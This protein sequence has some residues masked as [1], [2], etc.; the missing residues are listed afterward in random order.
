MTAY[1]SSEVKRTLNVCR[2]AES[3]IE[4]SNNRLE[5]VLET[6]HECLMNMD[7]ASVEDV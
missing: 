5:C 3:S 7:A 1:E 2:T 4:M 6:F